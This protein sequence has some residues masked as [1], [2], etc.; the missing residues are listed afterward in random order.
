MGEDANSPTGGDDVDSLGVLNH[1]SE[2]A[3]RMGERFTCPSGW[4]LEGLSFVAVAAGIRGRRERQPR[5][6]VQRVATPATLG[7]F[8]IRSRSRD[9]GLRHNK[10][11]QPCGR[12]SQ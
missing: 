2:G 11:S 7:S 12:M 4:V 6:L 3:K 10:A 5:Q 9:G 8:R 1:R